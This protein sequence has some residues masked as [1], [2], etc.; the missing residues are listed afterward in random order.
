MS[1]LDLARIIIYRFHEKGLEIFLINNEMKQDNDIWKIPQGLTHQLKEDALL[2]NVI[3]LDE[4]EDEHGRTIKTFAIEGDW[5]DIPSIRGM[6]KHDV[7]LVKSIVK[8]NLPGSEKGAYFAIK[9]AV[10]KVMPQEYKAI[11][12]LKEILFDRNS[13]TNI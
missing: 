13:V 2:K 11:K 8:E 10:R 9:E 6:L 3:D 12:E 1:V 4:T 7:K 5:H